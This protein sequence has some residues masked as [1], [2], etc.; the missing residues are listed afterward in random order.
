MVPNKIA[1]K[2]AEAVSDASFISQRTVFFKIAGYYPLMSYKTSTKKGRQKK[3]KR[4]GGR[5]EGRKGRRKEGRKKIES[6]RQH[7]LI[8]AISILYSSYMYA[9]II[10]QIVFFIVKKVCKQL[11]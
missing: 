1:G 3:N 8:T 10:M 7:F 5:K 4:E 2:K 9:F 6:K 11:P